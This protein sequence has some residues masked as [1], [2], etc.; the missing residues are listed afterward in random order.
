[1]QGS[2]SGIW[3]H[4][5][6]RVDFGVH[7]KYRITAQNGQ[8]LDKADPYAFGAELRPNTASIVTDVD[9][10]TWHDQSWMTNRQKRQALNQPMSTYEVHLG[11]W[12]RGEDNRLLTYA[13]LADKLI[14]YVQ[15][16]GFTHIELLPVAEHPFDGSWG[17]Q[18]GGYYAPTS[19]FGSPEDFQAFVDACHQADIGVLVDWVPAHYPKDAHG[20]GNFDGTHLYEHA[21]PRQGEHKDW[22]TYIFNFGRNE[23]QCLFFPMLFFGWKN[24]ILMASG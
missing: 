11:S 8:I 18:V 13:E 22:G 21:D 14:P 16:M 17:Y 15:E 5:E 12:M 6:S 10:F 3:T 2:A 4:F 7:Y 9:N 20:L 24:T 1:M 23:V 19:R